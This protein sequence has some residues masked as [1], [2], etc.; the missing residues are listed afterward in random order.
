[1]E[2][3][4]LSF[5]TGASAP[6]FLCPMGHLNRMATKKRT[7]ARHALFKNGPIPIG[8]FFLKAP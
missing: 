6:V 2:N 3:V 8:S 1:M 5:T 7:E 4:F